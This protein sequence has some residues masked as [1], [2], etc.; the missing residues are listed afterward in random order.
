MPEWTVVCTY[1]IEGEPARL[2]YDACQAPNPA[3]AA[4]KVAAKCPGEPTDVLVFRG[5]VYDVG[6]EGARA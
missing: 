2:F 6:T 1:T 3:M 5:D 4:V